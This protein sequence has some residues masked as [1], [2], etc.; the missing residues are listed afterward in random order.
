[1]EQKPTHELLGI[2]NAENK[3]QYM[4][5]ALEA[6]RMVLTARGVEIPGGEDGDPKS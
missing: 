2:L 5:E 3:D 1:M 6:V 4:P